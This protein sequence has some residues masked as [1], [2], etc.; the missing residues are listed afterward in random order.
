VCASSA[1]C[2]LLAGTYNVA[3]F[4][5]YSAIADMKCPDAPANSS[6]PLNP[7][8]TSTTLRRLNWLVNTYYD[9]SIGVNETCV[10]NGSVAAGEY[11]SLNATV[12]GVYG[13]PSSNDMQAAVWTITGKPHT[14]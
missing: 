3:S 12:A 4:S 10:L 7:N 11:Q 9:P 6:T 13:L 14:A 2:L 8:I 5:S 1:Y